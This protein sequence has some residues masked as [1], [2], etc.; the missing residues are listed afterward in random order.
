MEVD[1]GRA[2]GE[3][4]NGGC[5]T[6]RSEYQAQQFRSLL[7]SDCIAKDNKLKAE[8]SISWLI[9]PTFDPRHRLL[10]LTRWLPP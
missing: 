8:A 4:K 6:K 5:P 7:P 10:L 3:Y 2:L 1:G 9:L